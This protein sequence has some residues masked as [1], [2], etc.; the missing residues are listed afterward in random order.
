[1]APCRGGRLVDTR[2]VRGGCGVC[3]VGGEEGEEG[4]VGHAVGDPTLA[5]RALAA[6]FS[7]SETSY[8]R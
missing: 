8:E 5:Q 4:E 1:M 3:A 2:V 7:Q 6:A